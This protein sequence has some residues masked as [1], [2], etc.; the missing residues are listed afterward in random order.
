MDGKVQADCFVRWACM[1]GGR[2][3]LANLAT[4]PGISVC[5]LNAS[6]RCILHG[7]AGWK[8]RAKLSAHGIAA[9][10]HIT[11]CTWKIRAVF[12]A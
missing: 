8:E 2:N 4:L 9:L 6:A 1:C 3:L 12:Q 11:R 7:R 5:A 10:K